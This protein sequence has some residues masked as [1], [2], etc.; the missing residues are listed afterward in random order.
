MRPGPYFVI[1]GRYAPL[2]LWETSL[3]AV[4]YRG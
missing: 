3:S 4:T 2:L 1:T